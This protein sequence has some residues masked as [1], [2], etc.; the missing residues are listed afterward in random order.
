V[1]CLLEESLEYVVELAT[2]AAKDTGIVEAFAD[3]EPL[4][5]D[6]V[7]LLMEECSVVFEWL[8]PV[9]FVVLKPAPR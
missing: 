9:V 5:T 1:E 7:V 8:V 3:E 2:F 4:E 6:F